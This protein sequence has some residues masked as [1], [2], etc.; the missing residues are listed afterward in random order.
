MNKP[1]TIWVCHDKGG[2][3]FSKAS[4]LGVIKPVF[5]GEFNPFDLHAAR[6]HAE[7]VL[8]DSLP[9]DWMIGVGNGIAQ[10]LVAAVF[11]AMH[12]RFPVLVYHTSRFEYIK[13]DLDGMHK[14]IAT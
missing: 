5:K 10:M 1:P 2:Y 9:S 11:V 12:D 3:D 4:P 13:R 8:K 6:L 7:T 14:L